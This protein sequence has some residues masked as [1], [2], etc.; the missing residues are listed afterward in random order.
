MKFAFF[1]KIWKP[2]YLKKL[3]FVSILENF[4]ISSVNGTDELTIANIWT[5]ELTNMAWDKVSTAEV[6]SS[7]GQI[8]PT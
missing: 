2:K 8:Y 6:Q 5:F 7:H 3:Y 4:I 1:K